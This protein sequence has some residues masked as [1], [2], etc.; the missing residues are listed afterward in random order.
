MVNGGHDMWGAAGV[1]REASA[2]GGRVK[3]GAIW[4]V[5]GGLAA[6]SVTSLTIVAAPVGAVLVIVMLRRTVIT[7]TPWFVTPFWLSAV[8][9]VYA[10]RQRGVSACGID[11]VS[12]GSVTVLPGQTYTSACGGWSAGALV[13]VAVAAALVGIVGWAVARRW[14][15]S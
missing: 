3:S 11:G 10:F 13:I 1:V 7:S 12:S 4:F 2:D 14:R 5:I 15:V 6:L 9:A 8:V